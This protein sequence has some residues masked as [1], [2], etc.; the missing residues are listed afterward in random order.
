MKHLGDWV[1]PD[2]SSHAKRNS[3]YYLD[4]ATV[5]LRNAGIC[6]RA[7]DHGHRKH[8]ACAFAFQMGWALQP[9]LAPI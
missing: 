1:V 5:V 8:T 3:Y 6:R 9:R 2:L 7:D 4:P